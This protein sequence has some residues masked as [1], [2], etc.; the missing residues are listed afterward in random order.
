[1]LYE[2]SDTMQRNMYNNRMEPFELK[3]YGPNPFVVNIHNATEKNNNYRAALWTGNYLQLTLM[4][5]KP[6]E[7]IGLEMHSNVDQ[8]IRIENGHAV[9]KIGNTKD[10]LDYQ[11]KIDN[12]F[13]VII[14][15]GKWHNIVN[16]GNS[17]LKLYSV[18]APPKHPFGTIQQNKENNKENNHQ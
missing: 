17:P 4:S 5:L 7:D 12:N 11:K 14:P 6:G 2:G 13:A 9:V 16:M 8:F 1:M 15:A 18:Y 10:N 3:D